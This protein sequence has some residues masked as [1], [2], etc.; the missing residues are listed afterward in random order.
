MLQKKIFRFSP[1]ME[2]VLKISGGFPR[3]GNASKKNYLVFP[4]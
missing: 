1:L 2:S 3:E 4:P